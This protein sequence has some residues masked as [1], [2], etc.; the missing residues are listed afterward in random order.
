MESTDNI[1]IVE[2]ESRLQL[3]EFALDLPPL[4]VQGFDDPTV[5]HCSLDMGIMGTIIVGKKFVIIYFGWGH[6]QA[7]KK[8]YASNPSLTDSGGCTYTLIFETLDVS[9]LD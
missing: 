8:S 1:S 3:L 4:V 2:A 9:R 5:R 7:T 6:V